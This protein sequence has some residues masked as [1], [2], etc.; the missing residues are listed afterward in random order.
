MNIRHAM[1]CPLLLFICGGDAVY[2]IIISL[3][4]IAIM[5]RCKQI[6][7][8]LLEQFGGVNCIDDNHNSTG[9]S[10]LLRAVSNLEN[11]SKKVDFLSAIVRK[12]LTPLSHKNWE[13]S[14]VRF[15]RGICASAYAVHQ[16]TY[17]IVL[18]VEVKGRCVVIACCFCHNAI[19]AILV[20]VMM[21]SR[22]QVRIFMPS[23]QS[24]I[25]QRR[26]A[27][28]F[29]VLERFALYVASG[30]YDN[31]TR[32]VNWSHC[33]FGDLDLDSKQ[34]KTI[35]SKYGIKQLQTKLIWLLD[36][37]DHC[38]ELMRSIGGRNVTIP[39]YLHRLL[40]DVCTTADVSVNNPNYWNNATS[41][42]FASIEQPCLLDSVCRGFLPVFEEHLQDHL[43][44]HP[45]IRLKP[46][47]LKTPKHRIQE[48]HTDFKRSILDE[49]P[50][51][52]FLAFTP[53][54][55]AGMFLQIWP[56]ED[57]R[58]VVVFVP[59]GKLLLMPGSVL[60]GGGFLTCSIR[61]NLRMHFYIYLG[62]SAS[63][64][65]QQANEYS[66]EGSYRIATAIEDGS[67]DVLFDG[68]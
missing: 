2:I 11:H 22:R 67:L 53:L 9:C 23:E 61:H 7:D 19:A 29:R 36:D 24:R 48:R 63:R 12:F 5:N 66:E 46:S 1:E 44:N 3:L 39:Q 10:C 55:E 4:L 33:C 37:D 50:D 14:L 26:K 68:M 8:S 43:Q 64:N 65:I 15:L 13:S 32:R 45:G 58:G 25:T 40:Y 49:Y 51:E 16:R 21:T 52:L 54:T 57:E 35:C 27:T 28:V 18:S 42:K 47:V 59:H 34:L 6:A 38:E 62:K 30:C 17:E 56:W 60:H 41:V 31:T 20:S